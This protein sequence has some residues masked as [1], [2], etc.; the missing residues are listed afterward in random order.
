[1]RDFARELSQYR[2][3]DQR[4]ERLFRQ[5]GVPAD[6]TILQTRGELELLCAF[7]ER[8]QVSS[9]LE[10][11]SWTGRLVLALQELFNFERVA[12]CDLGLATSFGLPFHLDAASFP[13]FRGSSHSE[14]FRRW[15]AELG[16]VDVTIIDGD[17]SY[18]GVLRD[19]EINSQ[20]PGRFLVFHDIVGAHPSTEGVRRFW[21]ELEGDKVELCAPHVE[22][23]FDSPTMG[24]GIWR[25]GSGIH[26]RRGES[27]REE[28]P[29]V[30]VVV[31]VRD[32][33][34]RLPFCLTALEDQHYPPHRFEVLVVDDGSTETLAPL[35]GKF[36]HAR[37]LSCPPMGPAA[38]RNAGV[39]AARGEFV[40]FTD[41]DC[42]PNPDWLLRG[43]AALHRTSADLVGGRIRLHVG[44]P[45]RPTAVE[46]YELALFG[47]QQQF[48]ERL[49]FAATANV[50]VRREAAKK[51]PFDARSFDSASGEDMEWGSRLGAAGFVQR[52]A[53]DVEV[54]HPARQS[55]RSLLSK[56]RL[57]VR[58]LQKVL[59][60][61]AGES[62]TNDAAATIRG[63]ASGFV[64]A[65]LLP[66][67]IS[68][69]TRV[70]FALLCAAI[71][72]VGWLERR[73]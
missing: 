20:F 27:A 63:L 38:A 46:L 5:G 51:V 71:A 16:A 37:L 15:R 24:I 49:S 1:M 26:R 2:C 62:S 41:A 35:V 3:W 17:H 33:S 39:E 56:E 19:F 21:E 57:R 10:I 60:M 36:A 68:I 50:F 29:F 66:P 12:A 34:E 61:R 55:V 58:G 31:P 23:G 43:I 64:G 47:A 7:L 59:E 4:T 44:D 70:R 42:I 22:A 25:V 53:D 30:S 40:A 65:K 48:I 28:L 8:E 54:L 73:R 52:Y 45:Q 9:L 69:W 6:D 72:A 11:G 67:Q 14:E 13:V 32:G 18:E